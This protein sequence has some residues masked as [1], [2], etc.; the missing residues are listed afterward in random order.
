[1]NDFTQIYT[2]LNSIRNESSLNNGRSKTP[3]LGRKILTKKV[4]REIKSITRNLKK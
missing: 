3:N 1:M 2:G 4:E